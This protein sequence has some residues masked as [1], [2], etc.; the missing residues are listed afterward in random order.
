LI[1]A[2]SAIKYIIIESLFDI[3]ATK[4][5]TEILDFRISLAK[6]ELPN[7]YKP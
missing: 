2:K 3:S 5:N 1:I 4:L 7:S 6:T